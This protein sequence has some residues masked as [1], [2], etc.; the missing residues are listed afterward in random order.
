LGADGRGNGGGPPQT[1]RPAV[2]L[3]RGR[4]ACARP[5]T[6]ASPSC[7]RRP[8]LY[9]VGCL[10]RLSQFAETEDGRLLI[11]LSGLIRFTVAEELPLHP[12]GFREVRPDYGPFEAD[13]SPA[14]PSLDRAVLEEAMR[15]YFKAQSIGADWEAIAST[16]DAMLVTTLCMACP[17]EPREKQAL[18]EAPDPDARAEMLVTLMRIGA[19]GPA[20]GG[21]EDSRSTLS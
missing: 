2:Q 10:G 18:L 7:R 6:H 21:P 8:G 11:T 3:R 1:L 5:F 19:A 13:L 17:F 16:P 15:A 14:P 9:R 12:G 20:P 4:E